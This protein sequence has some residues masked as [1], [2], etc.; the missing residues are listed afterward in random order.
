MR[1][2]D[3]YNY[4]AMAAYILMGGAALYFYFSGKKK[5]GI[6][7]SDKA[8]RI[9][10]V[11]VM[12]VAA[13]LR[14][15][16]LGTVPYGLQQD[17]ASIGYE[18]YILSNF[19][20][21]RDGYHFPVYPITWGCGGGSPL[22]IYLNVISIA[23]FGPGILKLRLIPAVCGILTVFLFYKTLRLGFEEKSYRNEASLL[24]AAFLAISPWH[25]ILSRWSLDSNIM[26]FNLILSVYLYLLASK[27]KSSVIYCLSAAS[28]ALCMYSYGAATIVVPVTLFLIAI[29]SVKNKSLTIPQLAYSVVT[30]LV[31]FAPL[32]LFYAVNY[33]GVP[34]IITD[35]VTF[36]R[37]TAKRTGEAFVS[38]GGGFFKG[39]LGNL[40]ALLLTISVGNEKNT[41]AHYLPGYA[42]LFEFTFPVTFLGF[43]IGV[44]ELFSKD[45][46]K[47]RQGGILNA[48]FIF[49]TLGNVLLDMV[50]LPDIQRLVMLFIP[51]I[52]FF[53]RGAVFVFENLGRTAAIALTMILLLG[54][55]SFTRDYFTQYNR[56]TIS[57]FM[58]GYG[59][60]IKRAY[61][62]AGDDR[63]IRSTYDG[64]AAPFMIALYYNNYDP[65]RFTS[66]VMYKDE[67]AE[68]RIA[69]S[70]GNFIFELPQDVNSKEYEGDV[71]VV[72]SDDRNKFSDISMFTEE[73]FGGYHVLYK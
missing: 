24:G 27:K 70:F 66:T 15:Y 65:N 14:L 42:T 55:V 47:G 56:W 53:V 1:L 64:L 38:L 54:G 6:H 33:L 10:F 18:A 73:D 37:F 50:I 34:E 12:L 67:T 29:Y 21:D 60:A 69:E 17:E 51:L 62:I 25:V 57:I 45:D 68:F 52:Y 48:M 61:E 40:K 46:D 16:K 44:K 28:F 7:L 9:S 35:V 19:G 23:L 22:L 3:Y 72:S 8:L 31:V 49:V 32:L 63:T 30:F 58:P 39:I 5:A 71:F 4:I 36:N 59:D 13:A 11:V 20:I 43:V 41:I 26:P 2:I